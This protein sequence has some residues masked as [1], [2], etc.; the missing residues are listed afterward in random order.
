M[1]ITLISDLHLEISGPLDLSGG[2]VLII[3][4]DAC[5]AVSL[6][7]EFKSIKDDNYNVSAFPCLDFFQNQV[8][9]YEKVFYVLGNHEHYRGRFDKTKKILE[10]SVYKNVTIL[11]DDIFEYKG[12]MFL[13][14]TLW[15]DCN[16]ND[17]V[18]ILEL[19][20][21]MNDYKVI[22]YNYE[23][24]G[25]YHK[26]NPQVTIQKHRSTLK[27][28]REMWAKYPNNP[29]VVITHHAPSFLS[30]HEKYK[31]DKSINGGYASD[32]SN[33]ILDNPNIKF[34]VHG[35]MHTP[36]SYEIGSTNILANPRGYIPWEAS[37]GFD[38]SFSFEL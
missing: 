25:Y 26:L 31:D 1:K 20:N 12:V 2:D 33:D 19:K 4:G 3:A 30:V 11:D 17:P 8:S 22:T 18:T 27:Y 6:A 29:F 34:W 38:P 10:E 28:F 32:L 15:T 37:N 9:K 13:G 35:H 36:S 16:K 7:R 14:G 24:Q 21:Y 5:E 23:N